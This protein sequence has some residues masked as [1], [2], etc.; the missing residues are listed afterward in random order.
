MRVCVCVCVCSLIKYLLCSLSTRAR[1]H[2]NIFQ[3]CNMIITNVFRTH[4][5]YVNVLESYVN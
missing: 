4:A 5:L 2:L 1:Q 3:V